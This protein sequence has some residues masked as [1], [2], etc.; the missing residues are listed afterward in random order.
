MW[1][2]SNFSPPPAVF[3]MLGQGHSCEPYFKQAL[4]FTPRSTQ[5]NCEVGHSQI[6]LAQLT[7]LIDSFLS[8]HWGK[9]E[10][11]Y[12]QVFR[13]KMY[14]G[15]TKPRI[16]SMRTYL[17]NEV[18]RNYFSV[19][20]SICTKRSLLSVGMGELIRTSFPTLWLWL[21]VRNSQLLSNL[22]MSPFPARVAVS[23]STQKQ[24][25]WPSHQNKSAEH[26][27]YDDGGPWETQMML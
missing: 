23:A 8:P 25:M 9:S 15:K 16:Y 6:S 3:T 24:P 5:I 4:I 14:I 19:K 10:H 18:W 27:S 13:E 22:V 7:R 2:I 11:W 12:N 26:T 1:L 21:R 20:E 17:E